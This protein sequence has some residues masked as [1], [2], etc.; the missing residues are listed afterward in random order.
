MMFD[1]QEPMFVYPPAEARMQGYA[2]GSPPNYVPRNGHRWFPGRPGDM[3]ADGYFCKSCGLRMWTE[4]EDV[5][6]SKYTSDRDMPTC[7]ESA[8]EQVMEQ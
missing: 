5:I 3:Y 7:E 4:Y 1:K 2:Q 6:L 8:P